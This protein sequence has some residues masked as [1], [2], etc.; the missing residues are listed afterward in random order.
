[1]SNLSNFGRMRS[2]SA[3]QKTDLALVFALVKQAAGIWN[4]LPADIREEME[5]E[6]ADD[7]RL[8]HCLYW[9]EGVSE[10]YADEHSGLVEEGLQSLRPRMSR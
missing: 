8:G 7:K 3:E 2:L 5:S 4:S 1:M 10:K 6:T 9:A